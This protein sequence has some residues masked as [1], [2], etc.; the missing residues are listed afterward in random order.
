M[1]L[2]DP[3]VAKMWVDMGYQGKEL[4]EQMQKEYEID[5]EVVKRPPTRFWSHKDTP[6]DLLPEI[7]PGFQIQPRRWVV[8]RT[9]AWINR[10]RRLAKE[11]EF[12]PATSENLIYLA[13]NRLILWRFDKAV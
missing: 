2:K 8:E 11:F 7:E 1:K 5:L 12:L 10:N 9:F 3:D 4:K 13:M 6:V